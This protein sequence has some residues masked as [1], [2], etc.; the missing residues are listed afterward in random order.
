MSILPQTLFAKQQRRVVLVVDQTTYNRCS[1]SLEQF[2]KSLTYDNIE[3]ILL[4]DKWGVPDSIKVH[5][6]NLHINMGI[7]GALLIG[8]VP[9]PMIRDAQHLTTAFKINQKRDWRES[10]VPSDRF[11]DD[12]DLKFDFIKRD[13]SLQNYFYY[14]LSNESNHYIECDIYTSRI[15]APG[16]GDERY[17]LIDKFLIKAATKRGSRHAMRSIAYFAGHGYNSDCMVAR[18]DEKLAFAEQFPFISSIPSSID[19]ID[20]KYDDNVKYRLM[21]RLSDPDL[22]LAVLHHHGSEDTQYMNGSPITSDSRRWLEMTKKFF[23]GKIRQSDD[24][25]AAKRYYIDNYNVPESWVEGAFDPK[26]MERD[27]LEDAALDIHIDDLDGFRSGADVVILDA[28]FN[29]SFHLDDYIA[30]HHI[31]NKGETI[32]VKAN[33]VNTLQDTWTNQLMGLLEMGVCVGNWAKGMMTLESHLIGDASYSFK[34]SEN[35]KD[36]NLLLSANEVNAGVW[37]KMLKNSNS[38]VRSLAMKM[39]FGMGE[40]DSEYLLNVMK[41]SSVMTER[42]MAFTL[43]KSRAGEP[44][45]KAI[46]L[47]LYDNYELLRRLAAMTAGQNYSPEIADDVFKI[48]FNP[49]TS[50]R[51]EFQLKSACE[52]YNRDQAIAAY[53]N[54]IAGKEGKWYSSIKARR[55]SFVKGLERTAKEFADLT[56]GEG[57]SK[58]MRFTIMALRNSNSIAN[59]NILFDFMKRGEDK[60]LRIMLAEAFGWYRYS[61]KRDE[62]IEFCS[63]LA[64]KESDSDVKRELERTVYRLKRMSK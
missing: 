18:I 54:A 31:F 23:R 19:Y 38:E 59:L 24:T 28:C 7:E 36:L 52:G 30:A 62:I 17:S 22:D 57:K 63:N 21:A 8:D 5:L 47:G 39:L 46:K 64:S 16:K 15:K 20:H 53:D 4:I 51:V 45:A 48:R 44:L 35:G 49:A 37:K 9:V 41:T 27:S 29:G 61:C 56:N 13:S 1:N 25:S 10:S 26:I 33:S 32:V 60:E 34:G 50:K 2:S 58:N 40:I 43:I 55:G 12:F 14:S 42:L 3:P 6:R 11:Y